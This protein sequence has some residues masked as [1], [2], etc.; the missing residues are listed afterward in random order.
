MVQ[1]APVRRGCGPRLRE[2][3]RMEIKR[4]SCGGRST[5][6]RSELGLLDAR[7]AGVVRV[8]LD[9][10]HEAEAGQ[11]HD[12]D[13][14]AVAPVRDGDVLE[15]GLDVVAWVSAGCR[16]R[17]AE[18]NRNMSWE[19]GGKSRVMERPGW[20][21]EEGGEWTGGR[22]RSFAL[23]ASPPRRLAIVRAGHVVAHHDGERDEESEEPHR[24][25]HQQ[26]P[27]F[28]LRLHS[29]PPDASPSWSMS[30]FE[31]CRRQP[32]PARSQLP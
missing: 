16:R 32:R 7:A 1:T 12:R 27:A 29:L 25:T 15:H 10:L 19:G 21:L 8:L 17:W 2:P 14:R 24:V 22:S 28:A 26:R 4:G 23:T 11:V 31:F 9:R 13:V 30:V 20:R 3:E 6:A 5:K 18:R